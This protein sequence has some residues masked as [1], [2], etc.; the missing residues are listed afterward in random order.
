[1]RIGE[2]SAATGA[3]P[4]SLRYYEQQGLITAERSANGYRDYGDD[5]VDAVLRIRSLLDLGLPS[6]LV[7]V[8]LPCTGSGLDQ[9]PAD[10][11]VCRSLVERVTTIRDELAD[12]A[13]RMADTSATLTRFLDAAESRYQG[14]PT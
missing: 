13:A 6:E 9:A 11:Q 7:R 3:S 12:R 14:S 4:R 8:A 5:A 2:L 1:M 10:Q